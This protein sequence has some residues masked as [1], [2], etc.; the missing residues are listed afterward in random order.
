M[1]APE[2]PLTLAQFCKEKG[3]FGSI[4]E[5]H[6]VVSVR[7]MGLDLQLYR[8]LIERFP[9]SSAS[10]ILRTAIRLLHKESDSSDQS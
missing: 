9:E 10:D 8:A 2:K 1:A 6:S 5:G 4:E 3:L 7:L